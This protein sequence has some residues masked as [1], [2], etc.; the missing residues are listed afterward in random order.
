MQRR[1]EPWARALFERNHVPRVAM[2]AC[3]VLQV[4]DPDR[5]RR[6][7]RPASWFI[8]DRLT[9]VTDA[10]LGGV[11]ADAPARELADPLLVL[12]SD[13]ELDRPLPAFFAPVG[14]R[15]PLIDDHRRLAVALARRGVVH[16]APEYAGEP[17]AF[18]ALMFRANARR[19]WRDAFAFLDDN[20]QSW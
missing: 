11:A 17:H 8:L 16:E 3:G 13:V 4:S 10:Y 14:T 7:E 6:R 15:D 1:P 18:H 5:F 19:C 20:L 2:P 12:E 9:E